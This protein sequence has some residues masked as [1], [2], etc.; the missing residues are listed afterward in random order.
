MKILVTPTSLQEG[1][2]SA[3]LDTLKAFSSDLVFN[4]TGRPLTE[5]ELIPL[6]K[7][8]DG[9]VAGLDYVTEKVL[10]SCSHLK[11]VS[12]YGA[13]VDR[14]D[15][16]AAK[17]HGIVVTNTPGVNA[18]A[19]AELAFG[20]ILS[21]ARKISYL[22]KKTREGEW[23]RSTGMELG[24]KTI[25]IMGLG[26]IGKNV[27][28][29]AQGFGMKV[30]A[31]DP[32]I[33]EAY[34][35]DNNITVATFDEVADNADVISLHL[36]LTNET[37]HLI[38]RDVMSKMKKTAI[39]INTSRGGII[40]ED[41]AYELLKNG[42]LGGLGLDAFETE[43][44][45]N[46]PLFELNN[47]VVTPHTGAHTTEA[48]DNMAVAAVKNLIDVLSGNGCPFICNK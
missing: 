14:V 35:K 30:M 2:K 37:K 29:Y 19:V 5:D 6:L 21:I 46:S 15:L 33:N 44:P 41:A 26:A 11:V 23:V 28:R 38:S 27:A 31:Y 47:V 3:A 4:S 12:R 48:T 24:G 7:D 22:D 36:P 43:P 18:V 13:G 32:Y 10:K 39:L 45:T 16:A 17:E 40:D 8:C 20:L 25:G 1:K 9:Y 34:A 42:E